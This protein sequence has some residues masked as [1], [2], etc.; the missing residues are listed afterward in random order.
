MK[1][2]MLVERLVGIMGKYG[3]RLKGN[4]AA[5]V[6]G[7]LLEIQFCDVHKYI[8]LEDG[9]G[10]DG[11]VLKNITFQLRGKTIT[12][13]A[14]DKIEIKSKSGFAKGKVVAYD[15]DKKRDNYKWLVIMMFNYTETRVAI[16]HHD[17]FNEKIIDADGV[18]LSLNLEETIQKNSIF[19]DLFLE[20][21]YLNYDLI[22][23]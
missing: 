1:K 8:E 13:K 23:S 11:I 18:G 5:V 7:Q 22:A 19:T 4:A 15:D 12:M 9:D 2:V 21:E 6:T 20:N 14:D 16:I 10:Y 3:P 17:E